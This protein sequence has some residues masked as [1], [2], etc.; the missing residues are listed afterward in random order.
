MNRTMCS[1]LSK[2]IV[3]VVCLH[4]VFLA[5]F[6]FHEHMIKSEIIFY[7]YLKCLALFTVI[8]GIVYIFVARTKNFQNHFI[9]T[10]ALVI[11][12]LSSYSFNITFPTVIER[13]YSICLIDLVGEREEGIALSEL[14]QKLIDEFYSPYQTEKRIKEQLA[15]NTIIVHGDNIRLSTRGK[16][17]L[18]F[19]NLLRKAFNIDSPSTK[20]K[21][22]EKQ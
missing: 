18:G 17:L 10:Y 2:V 7:G 22:N 6:A 11:F 20:H 13:S 12:I 15:I 21:F 5:L 4:I 14:N 16:I 9:F 3:L 19:N 1:E 8:C